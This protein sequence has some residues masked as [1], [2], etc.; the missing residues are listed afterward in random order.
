VAAF[1]EEND[2]AFLFFVGQRVCWRSEA[3]A[4]NVGHVP[5]LDLFLQKSHDAGGSHAFTDKSKS[6]AGDKR[7]SKRF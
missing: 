7:N 1:F 3:P 4:G 6:M 5:Y 2:D